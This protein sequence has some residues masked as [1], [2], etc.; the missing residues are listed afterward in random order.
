MIAYP[1]NYVEGHFNNLKATF[2]NNAV[3]CASTMVYVYG[4]PLHS[5]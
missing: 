5:N 2:K 1:F 3:I 4:Q